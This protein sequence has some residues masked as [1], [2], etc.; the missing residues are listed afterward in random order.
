MKIGLVTPY[1]FPLPG[2]VNAHVG[3]LY[4]NL[5]KRGH[6]VRIISA[7][8]GPQRSSEG[9]IIRLG[10]GWSVP[11][12]GS[13]GTL[14]VSHRYPQLVKEMLERERFDVIHFRE[15]FVPFLSLVILRHSK[16]VNI[17]TFHAYS[18]FSPSYEF[19]KRFMRTPEQ[20]ADTAVWLATAPE[21]EGV[22]GKYFAD[23]KE[24]KPSAAA[25]SPE[26]ARRL[27]EISERLV[28]A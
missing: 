27:W 10:Y 16:A 28:A 14:T 3:Y 2:G 26:S 1:I 24:R 17:A 15:P 19:G 6:D 7:T 11:T 25:S 20:G 12:N 23:R 13:V 5:V 8:H 9:D 18:G 21:L 4:E 22:T